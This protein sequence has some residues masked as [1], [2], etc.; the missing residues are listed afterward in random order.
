M[1]QLSHD[2]VHNTKHKLS[3]IL[4]CD[5]LQSP[6][7]LG[8][9]CRIADSFGVSKLYIHQSNIDFLNSSRFKKTAR[10]SDKCI[11]FES[12]TDFSALHLSLK[13]NQF[14]SIALEYCDNSMALPK[15]RFNNK[16]AL[17]VGNEIY[18]LPDNVLKCVDKVAHIEMYGKN[19]S[20][21][22]AQASSIAL[23]E[24]INQQL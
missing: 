20:M 24:C 22:V 23:Y 7:N 3:I 1:K 13:E 19:T 21:N 12:Y 11:Y 18:G 2:L 5:N 17:V 9:I 10:Q 6:S 8:S 15:I 16:T 14:E 4:I